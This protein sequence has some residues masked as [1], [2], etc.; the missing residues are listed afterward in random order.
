MLQGSPPRPGN[1]VEHIP[2]FMRPRIP[3]SRQPARAS[4]ARRTSA[5]SPS[6]TK[7]AQRFIHPYPYRKLGGEKRNLASLERCDRLRQVAHILFLRCGNHEPQPTALSTVH[8]LHNNSA[9]RRT[10]ILRC[11]S[12]IVP[13]PPVSQKPPTEAETSRNSLSWT[14]LQGTPLF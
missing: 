14:I 4:L 3:V 8:C 7:S 6:S 11:F 2:P 10:I 13:A 9:A 1:I 5:A 12:S